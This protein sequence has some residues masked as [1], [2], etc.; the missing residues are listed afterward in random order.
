MLNIITALYIEAKEIIKHFSLKPD[1]S[2]FRNGYINLAVTGSGKI[3]SAVSTALVL[4]KNRYP[5]INFGIAGSNCYEIN[6]GFFIYKIKDLCSQKEYYPDF[7]SEPSSEIICVDKTGDYYNLVDMESSGFFEAAY[8]FLN[9]EEIMLY[10]IVSDTP[11]KKPDEKEIPSLIKSHL[12]TIEKI[13]D[14]LPK[15]ENFFKD[16][17]TALSEAEKKMKLTK[18][19]KEKLKQILTFYKIKEK[20]FPDFPVLKNKKEVQ[21]FITSL[22]F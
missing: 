21:E 17:Y 2:L 3:N 18:S 19:Q 20:N 12:I 15:K 11:L 1:S 4:Q 9:V 16:I 8:K 6:R 10:K 22:I 13:L 14:T 7:F 5:S